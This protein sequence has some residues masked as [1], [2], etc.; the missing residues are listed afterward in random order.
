[1]EP[2]KKEKQDKEAAFELYDWLQCIVI[3]IVVGILC[4]IFVARVITVEGDSMYPTLENGDMVLTQVCAYEQP[5]RGDIVIINAPHFD[6]E[7][8]V[9][10][11]I[12]IE[13][14]I[15]EVFD[16]GSV[17]VNGEQIDE[18]YVNESVFDGGSTE[19]PCYIGEG[20]VFVM[21]DNRNYS[22][23]SRMRSLGVLSTEDVIGKVFF[24]M[25][26]IGSF[27]GI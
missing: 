19:Y 21:G 10:R 27:G 7:P 15:V 4:F 17:Y 25:W 24:R 20:E 23:D 9:K 26:P 8:L 1:M 14:D 3:A 16:D 18:A 11:V 2:E 5:Q 22:A 13:G 12:G 6:E